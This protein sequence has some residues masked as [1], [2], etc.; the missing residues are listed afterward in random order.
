MIA[1]YILNENNLLATEYSVKFVNNNNAN[2]YIEELYIPTIADYHSPYLKR[3]YIRKNGECRLFIADGN[4]NEVFILL[5]TNV[6]EKY[7][8][9][10]SITPL[11][12]NNSGYTPTLLGWVKF[13][14]AGTDYFASNE[15]F[16]I[17][18][19]LTSSSL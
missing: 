1:E 13:K 6:T 3:M 18:M 12:L 14:Y 15:H 5:G 4:S 8:D 10:G 16:D 19:P 2:K 17:N 9:H 11:Y 7:Y